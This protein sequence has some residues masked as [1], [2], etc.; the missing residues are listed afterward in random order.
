[1]AHILT[2]IQR[3][4]PELINEIASQ[5]TA[6]IHEVMGKRGAVFHQSSHYLVVCVFADLRLP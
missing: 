1:M 6:T 5:S 3:L 2:N 4:N